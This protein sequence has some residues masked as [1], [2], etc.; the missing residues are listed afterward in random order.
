MAGHVTH[1]HAKFYEMSEIDGQPGVFHDRSID[2]AA[3]MGALRAGGFSR[4]TSTRNTRASATTRI[5]PGPT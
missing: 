1:V 4:A 5:G 2:T 3:A